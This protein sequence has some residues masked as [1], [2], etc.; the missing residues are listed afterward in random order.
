M[1]FPDAFV[2]EIFNGLLF[3]GCDRRKMGKVKPQPVMGHQ[4]PGLFDM[5]AQHLPQRCVQNMG[6]RCGSPQ[7]PA[8]VFI[9]FQ[10]EGVPFAALPPG[11]GTV[12]DVQTGRIRRG[13]C[14]INGAG[15]VFKH[16]G[17]SGLAPD[18][19]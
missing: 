1:I 15:I 19:A 7:F 11:H 10:K 17:I 3:V 14:D 8:P 6:W 18:S 13:L 9:H 2:Y 16:P 5:I 12:V 4:G